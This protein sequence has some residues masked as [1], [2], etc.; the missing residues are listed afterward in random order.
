MANIK[1]FDGAT[2]TCLWNRVRD[3]NPVW[4]YNIEHPQEVLKLHDEYIDAGASYI[5]TNTFGAN[6]PSVSRSEYTVE[7]VVR[8]G[9]CIAKRAAQGRATVVLDIGPP[10]GLLEPY[11]EISEE[12]AH[13]IFAEQ[14]GAGVKESPDAILLQTFFDIEILKI[15][16]AEARRFDLPLMCSMSFEKNGRTIMGHSPEMMIEQLAEFAPQVVGL[17]CSVLPADALAILEV[18]ISNTDLP[19]F[20]KPNAGKPNYE[21]GGSSVDMTAAE[22]VHEFID[23]PRHREIFAGGCCG[24]TPEYIKLLVSELTDK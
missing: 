7:R 2:G 14:I 10:P 22:Y 20:I 4:R 8:E 24:T 16:A 19:L 17:N 3:N 5:C 13:R 21:E 15:A 11:G 12:E 23:I 18:F 1:F 9:V 6:A